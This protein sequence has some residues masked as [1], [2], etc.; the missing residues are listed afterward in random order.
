MSSITQIQIFSKRVAFPV[1][2]IYDTVFSPYTSCAIE[3]YKMAFTVSANLFKGEVCIQ[4]KRLDFGKQWIIS[5]D[6][7][8]ACL[9]DTNSFVFEK[10][11]SSF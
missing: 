11:N 4:S 2:S 3:I 1:S 6:M 10:W 5:I 8:P 7:S 9:D